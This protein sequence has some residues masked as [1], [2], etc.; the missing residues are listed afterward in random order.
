[1]KKNNKNIEKK[2]KDVF[3]KVFNNC[4]QNYEN[5]SEKNESNWDSLKGVNLLL[6]IEKVF[7]IKISTYDLQNFNSFKNIKKILNNQ[8]NE[9]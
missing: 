9:K 4:N 2:L 3:K 6:E 7:A 5:F 1:M 8:I